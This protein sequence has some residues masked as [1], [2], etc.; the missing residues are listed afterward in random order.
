MRLFNLFLQSGARDFLYISSVKA[1]ADSVSGVLDERA[2]PDP[3]TPYGKSKLKAEEYLQSQK[4]PE[5]KRLFILRPCMI[6]GPNNKGNLNLLYRFAKKGIP[7]PLASF[8]NKRSFLSIDNLNF[9]IEK[10]I[11]ETAVA[12]G[13]YNVA[14]DEPLST[15]R[16]ITLFNEI[17]G[18]KN[19]LWK[20]NPFIIKA[21][22]GLGDKIKLPLNSSQLQKLTESYIVSNDK[23]KQAL[24][25]SRLPVTSSEGL[26]STIKSFVHNNNP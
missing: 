26:K 6:H 15:N 24:S 23:I 20:V 25:I 16:V 21:L 9:V 13:V 3:K 18:K 19:R 17:L 11:N 2:T 22:A 4:L 8:E 10:L 1:V 5:N 14:D 7:Y 12:G